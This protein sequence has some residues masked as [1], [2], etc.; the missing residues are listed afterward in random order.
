MNSITIKRETGASPVRSRHCKEG[1]LSIMS[2]G[3]REGRQCYDF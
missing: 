3:N 2:L 1:A